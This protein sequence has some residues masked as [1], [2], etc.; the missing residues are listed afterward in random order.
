MAPGLLTRRELAALPD[1]PGQDGP[2]HM[3]TV[4]KWEREAMPVAERG[5]RGRPSRYDEA[6][7]RA[8][9]QVRE[10][11]AKAG[12]PDLARER[13]RKER[14]QAVLA[15]QLYAV[16]AGKLVDA[17]TVEREQFEIARTVRDRIMNVPDHLVDLDRA[18]RDRVRAA[19]REA[20][21]ALADGLEA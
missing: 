4:T 20:L 11:T 19:L 1:L 17:A 14:A 8:W 18:V 15:E 2:V 7:V 3:Q 12:A 9:L 10:E 16:R 5:R 6:A 13:A 21:T